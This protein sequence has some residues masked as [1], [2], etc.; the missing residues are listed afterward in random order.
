MKVGNR[1]PNTN[2]KKRNPA[3]RNSEMI[4]IRKVGLPNKKS[5]L[6]QTPPAEPGSQIAAKPV[7]EL[8][9]WERLA[10]ESIFSRQALHR[11]PDHLPSANRRNQRN[12]IAFVENSVVFC[13]RTVDSYE[14]RFQSG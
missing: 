10:I 7:G 8:I 12:F 1:I 11:Q 6:I 13:I 5:F 9:T 14:Q 2:K 4:D 3:D